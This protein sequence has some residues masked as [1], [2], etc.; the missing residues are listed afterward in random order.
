MHPRRF[1][2]MTLLPPNQW[3]PRMAYLAYVAGRCRREEPIY[4]AW[5]YRPEPLNTEHGGR[6]D[7]SSH[8]WAA[9]IDIDFS[10]H[11]DLEAALRDYIHP[12][13]RLGE[14]RYMGVGV[15]WMRL[16]VDFFTDR[17]EELGRNRWWAYDSWS[18]YQGPQSF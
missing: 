4:C 17:G 16:H 18:S 12:M 5:L 10:N 14:H 6:T 11:I 7:K 15:G 1:R 2:D 9:G 8:I 13:Y 3:W